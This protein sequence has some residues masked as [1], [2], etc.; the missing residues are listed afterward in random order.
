MTT[1]TTKSD[2]AFN[3][4]IMRLINVCVSLHYAA[5]KRTVNSFVNT[6]S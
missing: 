4:D 3:V 2:S 6:R 1:I 5:L